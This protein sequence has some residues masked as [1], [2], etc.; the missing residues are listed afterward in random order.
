MVSLKTLDK[1]EDRLASQLGWR[2]KEIAAL[3]TAS[4]RASSSREYYCRAGAVMLCAHWE[5]FLKSAVQAYVD[6]V[7]AQGLLISQLKPPFVSIFFFK[8][9]RVA[10]EAKFPGSE[11][12]HIKLAK[13]IISGISSPCRQAGWTVDTEGNP[14]ST[15]LSQLLASVGLDGQMGRDATA[16][17]VTR[18]FIDSQILKDRHKIAHGERVYVSHSSF[19]DRS[20]RII[21][22]CE[23]LS[24]L[25]IAAANARS[26]EAGSAASI[27]SPPSHS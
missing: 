17:S 19:V 3:R 24:R 15:V 25:V 4:T 11:Q 23:D 20:N 8:A 7:F 9:V 13:K 1:L 16:W 5:G 27:D 26:Y 6:H 18:V 21:E 12:H 2:K 10:G 14:S 22:M